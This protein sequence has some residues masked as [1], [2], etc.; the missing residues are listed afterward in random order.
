MALCA[1]VVHLFRSYVIDY[2][3]KG[4][5]IRHVPIMKDKVLVLLLR[6]LVYVVD[7]SSIEG[8]GSSNDA[9]NFVSFR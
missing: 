9:V 1:E 6:I 2:I 3:V 7:P 5:R 8:A 4:F